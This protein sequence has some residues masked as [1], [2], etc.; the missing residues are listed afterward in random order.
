MPTI[1]CAAKHVHVSVPLMETWHFFKDTS[2]VFHLL[3]S[4]QAQTG[5][6]LPGI[7]GMVRAWD[8]QPTAASPYALSSRRAL[9][10]AARTR[11][12]CLGQVSTAA[13]ISACTSCCPLPAIQSSS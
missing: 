5:K 4:L 10:G 9:S 12:S 13:K 2:H 7:S 1:T 8:S 11:S 6:V 3:R